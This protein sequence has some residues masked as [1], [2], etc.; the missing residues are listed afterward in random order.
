MAAPAPDATAGAPQLQRRLG[1][2]SA[3]MIVIGSIIGS[4]IFLTPQNVAA[5]VQV[6]GLMILVWIISGVLT[7]A[8]AITNAE[9]GS[10]IPEAGG[11]YTFFH[12]L[13]GDLI[14]FLFGWA[15][16]IVYQT[17]SIAAIAMAFSR[18]LGYFVHLP[19]LSPEIEAWT[20]PYTAS[21]RSRKWVRRRS[22]SAS[23]SCSPP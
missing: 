21:P 13:Y 15:T 8:G 20:I 19:H 17:G 7:L 22:R 3:V 9:I 14:A 23:S 18:Y 12:V 5:A 16:F 11:H 6:P 2:T 10:A 1:F 4:G